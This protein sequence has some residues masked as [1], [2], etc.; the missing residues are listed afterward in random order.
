MKASTQARDLRYG[1]RRIGFELD[2]E[3]CD[4]QL[5]HVDAYAKE[6]KYKELGRSI[7]TSSSSSEQVPAGSSRSA[8]SIYGPLP[9]ELTL[10]PF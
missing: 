3:S 10:I 2:E 8:G 6:F 4:S 1:R 5:Q 9:R 7:T